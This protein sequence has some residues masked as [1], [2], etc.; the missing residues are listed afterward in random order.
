MCFYIVI[1]RLRCI[2]T[3]GKDTGIIG[4]ESRGG[5]TKQA[6]TELSKKVCFLY[7]SHFKARA[8]VF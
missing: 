3:I 8:C 6:V 7:S 4:A 1:D 5:P 2:A